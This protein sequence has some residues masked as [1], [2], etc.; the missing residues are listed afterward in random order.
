MSDPQMQPAPRTSHVKEFGY[1]AP[2]GELHIQFKD[3]AFIYVYS[4]V[5]PDL[6]S[7]LLKAD[8]PGQFH[9]Q[10]IRGTFKFNKIRPTPPQL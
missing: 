3:G 6:Y 7:R 5:P 1:D 9:H 2:S 10:Q 8:H 4:G